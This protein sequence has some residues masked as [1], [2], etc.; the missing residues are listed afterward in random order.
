MLA[1]V[2]ED[3]FDRQQG[4]EPHP[5]LVV[6]LDDGEPLYCEGWCVKEDALARVQSFDAH[7]T[8]RAFLLGGI[9]D[10]VG[11]PFYDRFEEDDE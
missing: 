5:Y 10:G 11:M 9:E 4:I 7:P 3:V 1:D 2:A 8:L 6:V